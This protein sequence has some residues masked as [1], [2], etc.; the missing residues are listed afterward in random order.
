MA[1]RGKRSHQV[2]VL[3]TERAPRLLM[4]VHAA[5]RRGLIRSCHDLSEGGLAVTLGEMVLA[6]EIGARV[7]LSKVPCDDPGLDNETRLFSESLTRFV[8]EVAPGQAGAFED[9]LSGFPCQPVGETQE[10]A[11]LIIASDDNLLLRATASELEAAWRPA[12]TRW[13]EDIDTTEEN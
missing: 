3:D 7:E 4:A 13:L 8:V 12:L 5:M 2:P 11:E 9:A 10:K 6:G 1:L